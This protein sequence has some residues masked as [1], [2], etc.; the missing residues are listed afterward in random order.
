MSTFPSLL[1]LAVIVLKLS[2]TVVRSM[3]PE[4]GIVLL[5]CTSLAFD[6]VTFPISISAMLVLNIRSPKSM[7]TVDGL[8]RVRLPTTFEP[9]G[10]GVERSWR[11]LRVNPW[12]LFSP[13]TVTVLSN[14]IGALRAP[15]CRVVWPR[16]LISVVTELLWA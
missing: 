11:L 9:S 10:S 7:V 6:T 12:S 16:K 15:K 8:G 5:P 4:K 13:A 1:A 2:T 3:V 14:L